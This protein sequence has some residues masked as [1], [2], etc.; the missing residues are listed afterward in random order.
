MTL[1]KS[2]T[3]TAVGL[4]SLSLVARSGKL[5]KDSLNKPSLKKTTKGFVDLTLGMA[6]LKPISKLSNNLE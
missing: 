6:L 4:G 2:V 5:L 3:Q 1:T